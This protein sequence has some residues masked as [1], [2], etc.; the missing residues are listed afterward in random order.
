MPVYPEDPGQLEQT[1]G[2]TFSD[3]GLLIQALV[4]RSYQHEHPGAVMPS[5]ERIEFLGDAV[6]GLVIAEHLYHRYPELKE[7]EMTS[8]RA[9]VVKTPTLARLAA[10]VKLG[11]YLM[12]SK[13]E[14]SGGGRSRPAVLAC[15]YEAL[16]G[17]MLI[18]RGLDET[19]RFIIAHFEPVI[20]PIVRDKLDKDDKTNLQEQ[21]QGLLG[22]TPRYAIVATSG[23]QHEPLFTVE[24]SVGGQVLGT[25]VG[26]NK[27]EAEQLAAAEGLTRIDE[28]LKQRANQDI[29]DEST[30]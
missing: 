6:L 26:R 7:G 30:P 15:A 25:G 10:D 2:L 18:D 22:I 1:L 4:H 17:A 5:N 9:A 12:M 16:L 24:V 14:E 23:T 3:R 11:D 19:R 20:A 8:V 21:V 13:G 27:R 28:M 29:S